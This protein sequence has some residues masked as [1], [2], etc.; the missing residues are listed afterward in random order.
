MIYS[1]LN[2][3]LIIVGY[4]FFP[5]SVSVLKRRWIT[6]QILRDPMGQKFQGSSSTMKWCTL[7]ATIKMKTMAKRPKVD[8]Y[9][10]S[11]ELLPLGPLFGSF[12]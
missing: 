1:Y 9:A 6:A 2:L 3:W 12:Y 5:L 11:T 4:K 7:P 10:P 8:F